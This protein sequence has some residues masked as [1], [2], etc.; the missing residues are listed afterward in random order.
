LR[1]NFAS[2]MA[3]ALVDVKI[4]P[5]RNSAKA[6]PPIPCGLLVAFAWKENSPRENWLPIW[7]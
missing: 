2:A 5:S 6:L 3:T 4:S 1:W 7:L